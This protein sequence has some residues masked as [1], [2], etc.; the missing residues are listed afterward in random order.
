MA[1]MFNYVRPQKVAT[2]TFATFAKVPRDLLLTLIPPSV[3]GLKASRHG[4][5]RLLF[6]EEPIM[7]QRPPRPAG[8][9][10]LSPYLVVKDTAAAMDFLQRAFG[11]EKKFVMLGPDG[12]PKHVEMIY[13]DALV[14][15]GPEGGGCPGRSPATSGIV[16]PI[17]LYLYCDNV[18]AVFQRAMAAGAKVV[19]P[20]T[21]M[22]Y[23]DRVCTLTDPDGYSW[24]FATNVGDFDPTKAPH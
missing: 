4:T 6:Q 23:G 19:N 15:F 10:W 21:D 22:F 2:L 24:S 11:F 8:M 3:W 5:V 13:R 12:Q 14:M 9:P 17:G 7:A 20:P 16:S 1:I 18:D